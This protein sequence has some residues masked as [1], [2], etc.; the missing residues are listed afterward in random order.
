MAVEGIEPL[1]E[2]IPYGDIRGRDYCRYNVKRLM[3]P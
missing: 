1:E 2:E 3:A